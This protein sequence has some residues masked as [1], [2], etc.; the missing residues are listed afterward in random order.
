MPESPEAPESTPVIEVPPA[1]GD[2]GTPD[3]TPP[4]PDED[5]EVDLDEQAR[6]DAERDRELREKY[7][8]QEY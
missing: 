5:V 2:P 4:P 6:R 8:D 7:G 1:E 3:F